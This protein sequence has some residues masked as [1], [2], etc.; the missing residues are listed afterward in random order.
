MGQG[1]VLILQ[2]LR[3]EGTEALGMLLSDAA[4]RA[5]LQ[6][7]LGIRGDAHNSPYFEALIQ[8]EAVA[9]APVNIHIV[10]MRTIHR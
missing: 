5:Q 2:G 3:Q 10:T 1:N 4:D 9:G 8:T 6:Q 7:A